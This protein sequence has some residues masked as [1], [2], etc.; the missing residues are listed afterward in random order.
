MCPFEEPAPLEI[1]SESNVQADDDRC[2]SICTE[3]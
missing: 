3:N 1:V 2:A